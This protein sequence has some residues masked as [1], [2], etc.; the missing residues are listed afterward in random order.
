MSHDSDLAMAV[1]TKFTSLLNEI[2]ESKLNFMINLT[3]YAAYVTIKKTTQVDKNGCQM[4]PTPPVLRLFEESVR[5]KII[6]D[7]EIKQLKDLLVKS[8]SHCLDLTQENNSLREELSSINESLC[9]AH[10]MN[11]NLNRKILMKE[12]QAITFKTEKDTLKQEVSVL[13]KAHQE[14]VCTSNNKV[15][16]FKKSTT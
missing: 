1:N 11:E 8:E 15:A 5:E 7:S 6:A 10:I 2:Q 12:K 14:L 4:L 16:T 13:K 9:E 3:P